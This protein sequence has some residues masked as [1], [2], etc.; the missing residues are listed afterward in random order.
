MK[1]CDLV[2]VLSR[3]ATWILGRLLPLQGKVHL[4]AKARVLQL[5]Q[6]RVKAVYFLVKPYFNLG[7][8]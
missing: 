6:S 7:V 4:V 1:V 2:L 5:L 8:V 3:L